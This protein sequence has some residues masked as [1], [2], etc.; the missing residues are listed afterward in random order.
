MQP[1]HDTYLQPTY[2]EGNGHD[3]DST[4]NDF[5]AATPERLKIT[6]TTPVIARRAYLPAQSHSRGVGF[7]KSAL[8]RFLTLVRQKIL[9]SSPYRL[10]DFGTF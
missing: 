8:F 1:V 2:D 6:D 5:T 9:F 10:R 4:D 3:N 7:L